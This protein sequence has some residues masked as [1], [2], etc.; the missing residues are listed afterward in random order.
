M[1]MVQLGYWLAGALIVMVAAVH[2]ARILKGRG[3]RIDGGQA[4]GEPAVGYN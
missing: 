4:D 3:N 1:N 2:G